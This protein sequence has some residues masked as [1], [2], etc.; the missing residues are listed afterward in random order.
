MYTV[1]L[2]RSSEWIFKPMCYTGT[3]L[4]GW[5][6]KHVKVTLQFKCNCVTDKTYVSVNSTWPRK[7]S[8][9]IMTAG[10]SWFPVKKITLLNE[11]SSTST[12]CLKRLVQTTPAD[13]SESES[14]SDAYKQWNNISSLRT[15]KSSVKSKKTV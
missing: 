9:V 4:F 1:Q 11:L 14:S 2:T 10:F 15:H 3:L 7:K 8:G 12:L 13:P 5:I 6:N